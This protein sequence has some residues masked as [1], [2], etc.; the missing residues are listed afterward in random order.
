MKPTLWATLIACA[1]AAMVIAQIAIQ[2]QGY[3]P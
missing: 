2:N 3:V 1:T